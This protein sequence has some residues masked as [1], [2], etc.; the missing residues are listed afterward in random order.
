[1]SNQIENSLHI[2]KK[3]YLSMSEVEKRISDYI[4]NYPEKVVNMTTS[5]LASETGVS[6][7][8]IINFSKQI[9]FSGFTKLKINIA[10]S[11]ENHKSLIFE[12]VTEGD[13]PKTALH[14]MI[15]NTVS[16]FRSTYD[17]LSE[18]DLQNVADLLMN[19][20]KRIEIYGVGSSSMIANDAYYRLMRIGLPV[21]AVTDPHISS[22]SASLLDDKCLAIGISH[23]GRTN[24]TL[25]AME[26]AKS[27][28]AKTICITSYA[29]SPLAKICDISIVIAS[30]EAE[31]NREAVV[32]RLT[33][34][35]VL[36]SLC[37]FICYQ[38]KDETNELMENVIDII[39]KHRK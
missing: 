15:E 3:Q 17:I 35:L 6:E 20:K 22:I 34:L 23:S 13:S 5:F 31:V 30:K 38:R 27:K 18:E 26:I 4:L 7:G 10:Q 21:Y 32:S 12:D 24:E 14:K 8:S 16:A 36:D 11:L 19:V 28:N 9:G 33:Q 25:E 29:D 39:G 2:I 1:M 37:S